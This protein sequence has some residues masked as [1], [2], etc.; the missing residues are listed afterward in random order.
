GL[1]VTRHDAGIRH[2]ATHNVSEQADRDL[3]HSGFAT[4]RHAQAVTVEMVTAFVHS[5]PALL[6]VGLTTVTIGLAM[7]LGH[8]VCFGPVSSG[9]S[10]ICQLHVPRSGCSSDR[11]SPSNEGH[12]P[13]ATRSCPIRRPGPS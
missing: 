8:N 13:K 7:I 1:C 9:Q 6:A 2:V 4:H 10:L 3:L 12:L 5:Q 11:P